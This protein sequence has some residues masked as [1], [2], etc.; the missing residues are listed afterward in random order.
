MACL[1]NAISFKGVWKMEF[2]KG[3]TKD[4]SFYLRDGSEIKV[5]TMKQQ[6]TNYY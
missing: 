5:L 6:A 3:D 1:I 2:D 4:K